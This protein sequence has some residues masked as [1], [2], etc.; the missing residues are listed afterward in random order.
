MKNP[1]IRRALLIRC[2]LGVGA[3]LC[4]L[5]I[6]T[7]LLVRHSLLREID[8]SIID[9]AALLS[10]QVELEDGEVTF[11]WQEGL[12]TNDSL[13]LEG[14]FQFWDDRT[15]KSARSPT[16][17]TGS[18][19]KFTGPEG[20]PEIRTIILPNGNKARAVGL[21]VLPFVLPEEDAR[22]KASGRVVSP[23]SLPHTLVVAGDME[24]A[25]RTLER[26]RYMLISGTILTLGLGFALIDQVIRL[27]LRPITELNDHMR[28]RADHQLDCSLTMPGRFPEELAGLARNFDSL[29]ARVA[30]T[31]QRERDFVRH[32]AHELR[33]PIAGLQATLEL[34]LSRPRD[35]GA[36][37]SFLSDCRRSAGDLK[38]LVAR[39]SALARV[40]M[41]SQIEPQIETL[42]L[43]TIL[44]E[45]RQVFE[46]SAADRGMAIRMEPSA[47][48]LAVRGDRA[49]LRI[50][51]NNLLDNAVCHSSETGVIDI[52]C[53]DDTRRVRIM[54]SN[55]AT[56]L[57]ENIN[58]LFE[59]L[60]RLGHSAHEQGSHLGIGLTLSME[61]ANAMGG[62]LTACLSG[63][64]RIEFT[65]DLPSA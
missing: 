58:R 14:I 44:N 27:S 19:P 20:Q 6:A 63:G 17:G 42:T 34:A 10:N 25:N 36:Y 48:G 43:D 53:E 51:I 55:P 47:P 2:G 37:A 46:A 54:I 35:S 23:D 18:L 49:L 12:G 9:T 39:L 29:L 32:A 61:A 60:F 38:E 64:D 22:M 1:S 3:I 31:R 45:C 33:T 50:V 5:S 13:T 52:R 26:L 59:P 40:G 62:S 41:A 56:D 4:V 24:P 7:Y 15:G 8:R 65:L 57:P 30:V 21:R 28:D 16:L 11:E